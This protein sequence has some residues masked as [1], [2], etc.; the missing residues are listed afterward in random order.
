MLLFL[1][2]LNNME[3]W[4]TDIISAYLEALTAEK[5]CFTASPEFGELQGH[6]LIIYKALYRLRCSGKVFYLHL[7]TC[8]CTMGF[9]PCKSEPNIWLCKKDGLYEYVAV[10][11]NDLA[12]TSKDPTSIV[13][14]MVNISKG[15]F[16]IKALD[17]ITFH[18][19][20]DFFQDE[21]GTLCFVSHK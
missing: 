10:Y 20:C 12:I 13:T 8:L 5:V 16:K 18:L 15:N 21:N 2:E 4:S 11:V 14:D 7:A 3:T 1:A 17:S 6:T 19:D 9:T